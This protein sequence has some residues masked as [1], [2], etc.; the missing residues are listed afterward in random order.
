MR[1]TPYTRRFRSQGVLSG[2]SEVFRRTCANTLL[3]PPRRI[4]YP[5]PAVRMMTSAVNLVLAC[6]VHELLGPMSFRRTGSDS[7]RGEY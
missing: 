2:L 6:Y 7:H 5:L 4:R 1:I 3:P